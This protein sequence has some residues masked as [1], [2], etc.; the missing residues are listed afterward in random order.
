MSPYAI[1]RGRTTCALCTPPPSY[2]ILHDRECS[3]CGARTMV[4]WTP[5]GEFL[6]SRHIK[7][8]AGRA[9]WQKEYASIA[10][11]HAIE[12]EAEAAKDGEW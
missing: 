9:V 2:R 8:E 1:K 3:E 7:D 6:C 4:L 5:D 11:A 12:D 10:E